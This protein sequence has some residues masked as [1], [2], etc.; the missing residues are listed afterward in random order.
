MEENMKGV[1]KEDHISTNNFELLI[2]GLPPITPISVSGLEDELQTVQLPDRTNVSGGNR[3][4]SEF[5]VAIPMH[6]TIERAAMELWY[7]EGQD[8]VSPTY[9]KPGTLIFKK[10]SGAIGASFTLLGAFV[11]KRALPDAEMEGEGEMATVT[12]T[13]S[14]D[15]HLPI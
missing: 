11:K 2:I 4:P 3:G 7:L 12:Y 10:I 8:P 15:D 9:K 14:V 13:I 1:I 6:H 5:D